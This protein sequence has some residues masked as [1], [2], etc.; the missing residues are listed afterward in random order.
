MISAYTD[1]ALFSDPDPGPAVREL[2][3][4]GEF[5]W[6]PATR[7]VDDTVVDPA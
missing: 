6:L 4:R 3:E 1:E 7:L 2:R 5:E